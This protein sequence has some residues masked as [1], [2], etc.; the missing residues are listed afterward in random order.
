MRQLN[1][2]LLVKLGG[3]LGTESS[4]LWA[5]ILRGKY[6]HEGD[7]ES[8]RPTCSCSNVWR[9]IVETQEL[10]EQGMEHIIGDGRKTK[11][12]LHRWLDGK[13]PL[14]LTTREVLDDQR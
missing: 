13:K 1:S 6:C 12:W 5:T 2:A 9:G 4:A 7:L 14:L 3:R 8:P 11:F 10:M